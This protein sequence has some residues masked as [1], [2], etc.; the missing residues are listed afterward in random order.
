MYSQNVNKTLQNFLVRLKNHHQDINNQPYDSQF[1]IKP[2]S[3]IAVQADWQF[4]T[5]WA[6]TA[7]VIAHSNNNKNSGI[8]W[9]YLSYQPRT[10][11]QFKFGRLRTPFFAY[12]EVIDVGYAYHWLR[13]P[14]E[15]YASYLFNNYDGINVVQ[16]FENQYLTGSVEAYLGEFS[17]VVSQDGR[18]SDI[19]V[20]FLMGFSTQLNFDSL[21]LRAAFNRGDLAKSQPLFQASFAQ[22]RALF[23]TQQLGSLIDAVEL[24]GIFTFSQL[25]F[26]YDNFDYFFKGELTVFDHDYILIP[27]TTSFYLSSGYQY[28]DF[29]F[30]L[31]YASRNDRLDIMHN[32][33]EPTAEFALLHSVY[34]DLTASRIIGDQRSFTGGIRWDYTQNIALKSDLTKTY[35]GDE[36]SH[37]HTENLSFLIGVEWIF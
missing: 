23:E 1:S 33:V 6:A 7:Q 34:Q 32:I 20:S 37:S 16:S 24:K 10:T 30:H 25:G 15:V 21:T 14:D 2:N 3:L 26:S 17:G 5:N 19:D 29:L 28:Q 31:T 13:P 35:Y 22:L 12:S 18:E 36:V 9:L 27:R 11:T 4:S 8:E